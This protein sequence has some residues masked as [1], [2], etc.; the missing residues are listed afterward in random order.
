MINEAIKIGG[1][2]LLQNCHLA[3]SWM[4]QLELICQ[5]IQTEHINSEFRLWLTTIPTPTFPLFVLQNSVRITIEP[6]IGIR[7]S[8]IRSFQS[9]NPETFAQKSST[10]KKLYFA[11]CFFHAVIQNRKKFGPIGWNIPYQFTEE[12]LQVS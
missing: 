7:A 5:R 3:S 9:Q 12:D 11:L 6:P 1:W 8:L 2:V 4:S 10:Y